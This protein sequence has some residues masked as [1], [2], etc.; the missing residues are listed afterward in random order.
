MKAILSLYGSIIGYEDGELIKTHKDDF[1]H[2]KNITNGMVVV[3]GRK[4]VDT[5][6]KKLEGRIVLCLSN[7]IKG[8]PKADKVVDFFSVVTE[9]P[10]SRVFVTGGSEVY[11]KFAGLVTEAYVTIWKDVQL[12]DKPLVKLGEKFLAKLS[13]MSYDVYQEHEEFTIYHYYGG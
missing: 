5:L 6:P 7:T 8:H 9:Y 3:M 10:S 11:D 13:S 12:K 4:T 1:K 2:F